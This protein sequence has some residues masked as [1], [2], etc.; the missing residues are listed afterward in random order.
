[1]DCLSGILFM[2]T[3][4]ASITDEETLLR[5]NQVLYGCAKISVQKQASRLPR[6]DVF[7]LA[8]LAAAFEQIAA[9]PILSVFEHA[10]ARSGAAKFFGKK[11]KAREQQPIS[12]T[13]VF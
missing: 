12:E 8:N 3:P 2:G 13:Q 4:H 11:S 6:R 7:Q 10:G 9:I 5:H 1:M